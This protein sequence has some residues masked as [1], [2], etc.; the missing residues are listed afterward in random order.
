MNLSTDEVPGNLKKN[1]LPCSSDLS[2][3]SPFAVVTF[4][5]NYQNIYFRFFSSILLLLLTTKGDRSK[6]MFEDVLP[7]M[8]SKSGKGVGILLVASFLLM[9]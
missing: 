7:N 6:E 2:N 9:K 3:K 8:A 5:S 4:I 1:F